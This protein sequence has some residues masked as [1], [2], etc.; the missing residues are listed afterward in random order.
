MAMSKDRD[1]LVHV[2]FRVALLAG[3]AILSPIASEVAAQSSPAETG[4]PS[5]V[6]K[7]VSD[8]QKAASAGNLN[9]ALIQL[10]NAVRL[11]PSDGSV[12]AQLGMMLLATNQAVA[13]ERELRQ[14]LEDGAPRTVAVSGL[15]QAMILRN[16]DAQLLKEFP[17]PADAS[18]DP[19]APDILSARALALQR[20]GHPAEA[21]AAMDGSLRLRHDLAGL[22]NA[23]R[24]ASLQGDRDGGRVFADEAFRLAPNDER[25]L[26]L[27]IDFIRRSGD[28]VKALAVLDEFIKRQPKSFI[29]GIMRMELLLAGQQD[30]L[31]KQQLADLAKLAPRSPFV[32]YF[33][34]L[35]L[36]RAKDTRGA[37]RELQSLPQEFIQS[38]AQVSKAVAA[39]AAASGNL[40]SA[41]GIL[42]A[43]IAKH[44]E[45]KDA[46]LQLAAVRLAQKAPQRA[47]DVLGTAEDGDPVLEAVKAQAYLQM[48]RYNDAISSLEVATA[49]GS[50]NDLLKR[51]LALSELQV[52]Q[53]DQAI[54][55]LQDLI[56]RDPKNDGLRGALI[57][58]LLKAQKTDEALAQTDRSIKANP[59]SAIPL[60]QRG[61]V[62][63]AR[64]DLA[65]ATEAFDQAIAVDP[66]FLP[67]R[68]YRASVAL[69]RGNVEAAKQDLEQVITANPR[70]T[71]S[72]IRLAQ[73]AADFG[74]QNGAIAALNRAIKA[75][76]D[77]PAPRLAL[78]RYYASVKRFQDAQASLAAVLRMQPENADA[79][80][81]Q[82]QLQLSQGNPAQAI[83]TF[84]AIVQKNANAPEAYLLLARA[85]LAM[86][87]F[88]GAEQSVSKAADLVPASLQVRSTLIDVQIAAGKNDA[89]VATAQAL[90]KVNPGVDTDI[91]LSNTLF[92]VK[93][94]RDAEA[95]L[96]KSMASK[97]DARFVLGMA[98]MEAGSGDTK[99][100]NALMTGWLSKHPD[101]YAIRSARANLLISTGDEAGARRE[102]EDL[103]KRNPDD[104]M[105]LNNLGWLLQKENIVRALDLL[106]R[107][108]RIAPRSPEIV[109]TYG[110]LK[111][112][113]RDVQGALPL[114]QRAH[115]LS[116]N[117]GAIAYHLVLALDAAGKRSEAKTLLQSV[118]AKN[119]K[120]DGVEDAKKLL[121]RW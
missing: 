24:L 113:H 62:Y 13:A 20:Q 47:L 101:D 111:F 4:L 28:R 84:R 22:L 115:D 87:D 46:K 10:K 21:K 14:S 37:W 100:A 56:A 92:R 32:P 50:S 86:K 75:V 77:D 85:Q 53:S 95:L 41:G 8:A 35:M 16:E 117:D 97:P 23:A 66:K 121:A 29:A 89:A 39:I 17:E 72:Y 69:A 67:A 30:S 108:E 73:I 26:A 71:L 76:P 68:Y 5:D 3:V 18:K 27:E 90:Q 36:A 12:R 119:Q 48:G 2:A 114:I 91:L 34:G 98:R 109:D 120:F 116:P 81:L 55:S 19:A 64:A 103:L 6:Q 44:P 59:K 15:V 70:A 54:R 60:F 83:G 43:L 52:G 31:A 112:Q 118:L 51:Q 7:L 94:T 61:Q 38:D 78:A 11:A 99:K 80:A 110:W 40:E 58:A 93:R 25:A 107:A 65:H 102:Y 45:Q 79:V 106:A 9:L 105:A 63:V 74:D 88:A 33:R 57:A 1:R 96:E 82:G 49:S 104:P 42:T